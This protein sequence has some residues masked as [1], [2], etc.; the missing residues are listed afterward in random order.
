MRFIIFPLITCYSD[1]LSVT[2]VTMGATTATLPHPVL[3]TDRL[4]TTARP[5]IAL[6]AS[7]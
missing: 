4:Y 5:I 1:P 6:T 3:T 7:S 2:A